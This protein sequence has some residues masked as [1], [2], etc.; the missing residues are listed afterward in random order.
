[1]KDF[2]VLEPIIVNKRAYG[3]DEDI[4]DAVVKSVA[5][6]ILDIC[7]VSNKHKKAVQNLLGAER[8]AKIERLATRL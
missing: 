2:T 3:F 5:D 4:P 7:S 6:R 1:M 8:Y